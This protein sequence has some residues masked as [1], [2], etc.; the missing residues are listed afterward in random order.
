[1]LCLIIWALIKSFAGPE[2]ILSAL[3]LIGFSQIGSIYPQLGQIRFELIT[4]VAGILFVLISR[5]GRG[6][7][8]PSENAINKYFYFFVAVAVLSVPFSVDPGVSW[9]WV[10]YYFKRCWVLFF[11]CIVLIDTEKKLKNFIYIFLI[12]SFWL[13]L[14]SLINYFSGNNVIEVNGVLRV[15]GA[16][17][18]LA[19]P[20]GLANTIVQS[21]PF[22]YFTYFYFQKKSIKLLILSLGTVGIIGVF[23]SGSRGGFYGLISCML[24]IV[25]FSKRKKRTFLFAVLILAVSLSFA[26]SNLIDRYET[27][28]NPTN[29]GKSGDARIWGLRHGFSM[30]LKRPILGVGLGCF[31]IARQRWYGWRLWSHN[32]YGQLMGELGIL[33][34]ISW[35]LLIYHT[36]KCARRIRSEIKSSGL[37]EQYSFIYYLSMAIEVGIYTRLAL[38]M[39]THSMHIFFWY[40]C[41]GLIVSCSNIWFR[42]PKNLR[43]YI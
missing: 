43:V 19:N 6:A 10:E 28:L 7:L 15:K 40:L 38:G 9:F 18:I 26:G 21:I 35:S 34:I 17:G 31:D 11:I 42:R 5:K 37:F 20:N 1:M 39:S 24:F 22:F 27:I 14:G 23:L 16:T 29:M 36:V 25:L 4:G 30:L 8:S 12:G 41:A 13:S 2:R 32:H 3:F 33:G